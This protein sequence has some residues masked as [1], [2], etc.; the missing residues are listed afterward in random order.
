M[1]LDSCGQTIVTMPWR[2]IRRYG[3]SIAAVCFLASCAGDVTMQNP[4][5]GA[6]A[7]C[8]GSH[9]ELYPW[10]QTMG[11]VAN[12]EAQDWTRASTE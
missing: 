9:R 12:Y 10:S 3:I 4:R 2:A 11:C 1:N 5:N 8:S 6:T 7:F